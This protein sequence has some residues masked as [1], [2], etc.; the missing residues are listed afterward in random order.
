[1][2][3]SAERAFSI[4]ALLAL[5]AGASGGIGGLES[6]SGRGWAV[7]LR[8]PPSGAGTL[9]IVELMPSESLI[10]TR[11]LPSLANDGEHAVTIRATAQQVSATVRRAGFI[12]AELSADVT[13]SATELA[14]HAAGGAVVL[15]GLHAHVP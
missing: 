3:L 8:R 2:R 15:R 6:A 1:V 5:D 14:V 13:Q 12:V 7:R 9:E 4:D 10:A 11:P